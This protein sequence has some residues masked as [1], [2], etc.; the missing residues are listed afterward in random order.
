MSFNTS[1]CYQVLNTFTDVF[2][3]H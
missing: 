2:G 3:L 1:A